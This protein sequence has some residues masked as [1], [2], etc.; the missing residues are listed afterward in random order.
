MD[1]ARASLT[2]GR[3]N[4][5]RG[6]ARLPNHELLILYSGRPS[7]LSTGGKLKKALILLIRLILSKPA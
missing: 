4:E 2:D 6:Q 3:Q 7:N 5:E 1:L